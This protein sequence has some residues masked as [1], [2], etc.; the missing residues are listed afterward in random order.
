VKRKRESGP[1]SQFW[2]AFLTKSHELAIPSL[3][4]GAY[5]FV[6][7]LMTGETYRAKDG[8]AERPVHVSFAVSNHHRSH[9]SSSIFITNIIVNAG[10]FL[11]SRG[12]GCRSRCKRDLLAPVHIIWFIPFERRK[13][14]TALFPFNVTAVPPF[15][16]LFCIPMFDRIEMNVMKM[17]LQIRIIPNNMIPKP[18][19]PELQGLRG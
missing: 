2:L 13:V 6:E 16:R 5:V 1:I 10:S 11:C 8:K 19:L 17:I 14:Q 15:T 18:L 9:Y 12:I 7:L 3:L 4:H